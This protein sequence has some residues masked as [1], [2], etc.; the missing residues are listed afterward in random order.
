MLNT[1][2]AQK[3]L[4]EALDVRGVIVHLTQSYQQILKQHNYPPIVQRYLGEVL[5]AAALLVETIKLNGRMTIQFQSEGAIQLLV[6][7][8]NSE[9]HL[10]GL[11]Q[12]DPDATDEALS[13]GFGKGE[14]VITI[15]Q[16]GFER[17]MQGIVSLENRTI[18]EALTFYFLQSEQLPT[19]FSLAVTDQYAVGM[20]LQLMPEEKSDDHQKS[21]ELISKR[22]REINP[23]EIFYDNNASFLAY[24]FPD[25]LIRLFDAHELIFQCGCSI[26]KMENAIAVLGEAEANLIIKEKSE[27]VVTCE[28]CNHQYGF[29][30]EAVEAIFRKH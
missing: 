11:A 15:F 27:I 6:A 25:E 13:G 2:S 19:T 5:V 18:S 24:Y 16:K 22:V 20:L 17:P 30:R 1:D 28:Y 10:R 21:W 29:D 8:I 9:G 3:F 7:Q 26:E 23:S 12:W 4:F 14:L